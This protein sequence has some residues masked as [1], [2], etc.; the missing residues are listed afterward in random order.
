MQSLRQ[1]A[2]IKNPEPEEKVGFFKKVIGYLK[3]MLSDSH[4]DTAI[5][6]KRV[7]AFLA[8]ICCLIGFFVDLFSNYQI[9]QT[10]YD[11]MMWIVIAG[12][13]FTGLEKFAPKE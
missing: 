12:L 7:I 5:S 6:S 1:A 8:F 4:D 3:S 11:S 10:L 13:G 9:T 2:G